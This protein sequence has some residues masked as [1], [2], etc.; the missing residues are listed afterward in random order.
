[1]FSSIHLCHYTPTPIAQIYDIDD[2]GGPDD[3]L[4]SQSGYD[5]DSE[6]KKVT[7]VSSDIKSVDFET[8][9]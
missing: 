2:V 3:S 5:H 8:L 4:S 1:M 9:D 6:E 7:L